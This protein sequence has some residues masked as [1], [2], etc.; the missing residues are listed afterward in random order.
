[1]GRVAV[2]AGPTIVASV[3]LRR[4]T[5]GALRKQRYA[6]NNFLCEPAGVMAPRNTMCSSC[7]FLRRLNTDDFVSETEKHPST[8]RFAWRTDTSSTAE[9]DVSRKGNS[10]ETLCVSVP[11][12]PHWGRLKSN[13][14]SHH[15]EGGLVM[16][17]IFAVWR[18]RIEH[19]A[20]DT[21]KIEKASNVVLAFL[22]C[23]K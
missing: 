19:T 13:V 2:G 5:D 22:V 15:A 4:E 8:T 6:M 3:R 20:S 16:S 1:M 7:V 23:Y 17:R 14:C 18:S 21:A 10:L 9:R 12:F 11:V